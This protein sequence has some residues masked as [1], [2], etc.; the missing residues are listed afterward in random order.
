LSRG[1]FGLIRV[2]ILGAGN[3]GSRHLQSLAKSTAPI[4]LTVVDPSARAL[5]VSRQRFDEI[6]SG[7][8]VQK[9]RYLQ[10]LNDAGKEFD[11]CIVAT[12]SNIRRRVVEEL[13]ENSRVKYLILEKVAFQNSIDFEHVIDL[14]KSRN[15]KAWVNFPR[16]VVPFYMELRKMIK[17]SEQVFYSVEGGDWGLACNALHFVDVLSFLTGE[18]DYEVSCRSL[19]RNV[20]ESKRKG[21][22]EFT[23]SLHCYFRK[24]SELNLISQNNSTCPPLVTILTRS[25]LWVVEEEKGV[26][27]MAKEENNWK[28]EEVGF[29]WPYQSELT[30]KLV[31]EIIATGTCGLTSIEESYLIHKPLLGSFTDYLE[32]VTGKKYSAC[33]IT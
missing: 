9:P 10:D 12:N 28:W 25:M 4:E 15:T 16:R 11:L 6:A 29:K 27:R 23:G 20:K 17:P 5:E 33:P 14:L 18:T 3:I 7:K 1:K 19:D 24:G 32:R 30:H 31:E 2:L 26:A 13:L 8:T 22:V 21:F